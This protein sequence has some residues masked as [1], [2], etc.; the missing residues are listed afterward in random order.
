MEQNL[1]FFSQIGRIIEHL[2][3]EKLFAYLLQANFLGQGTGNSVIG[4]HPDE[5]TIV[6]ISS[7]FS[8]VNYPDFKEHL[9]EMVNYIDYLTEHLAS[10]MTTFLRPL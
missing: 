10:K 1:I 6:L 8:E 2:D 9:E 5:K 7:F 3:E 4:L